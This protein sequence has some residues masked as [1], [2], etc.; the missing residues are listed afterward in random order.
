M[1]LCT[2]KYIPLGAG[3]V[4]V[5]VFILLRHHIGSHT[6]SSEASMLSKTEIMEM[7]VTQSDF[8]V[9]SC[10]ELLGSCLLFSAMESYLAV[11][12]NRQLGVWKCMLHCAIFVFVVFSCGELLGSG[13]RWTT[14]SDRGGKHAGKCLW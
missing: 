12:K 10:G 2:D 5:A 1:Q 8:V 9:L 3:I 11:G 4:C 14:G 7:H 6:A 13:Q